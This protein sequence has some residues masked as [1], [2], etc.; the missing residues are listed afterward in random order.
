MNTVIGSS[1]SE[2]VF[3]TM[4]RI[5]ALLA[6]SLLG[7]RLCSECMALMPMGVAALSRPS[8]LAAKFMVMCP[9]AGCPAGTSG[10]RRRNSG[11][12]RRASWLI[13]PAFSAMLRKPS[14]R[15]MVPTS[16]R[17]MSTL[18]RAISNSAV[19]S[20]LNTSASPSPS[21]CQSAAAKALMKKPSQIQF[22]MS[23]QS[24]AA[25]GGRRGLS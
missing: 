4:N 21:H 19:T 24:A 23:G 15:V 9:S 2:E 11:V 18:S 1:V 25:Q 10:I 14:H 12:R 13:S 16:T 3:S 17:M 7:L 8:T 5:C 22:S 20:R 6:V